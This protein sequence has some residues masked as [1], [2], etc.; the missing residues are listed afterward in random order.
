MSDR[1]KSRILV[2]DD[3]ITVC[4]SIKMA[5]QDD[6]YEID[7]A[8]SG[9][10]ALQK[11][12]ES[13]YDLVITDLMMPGISGLDLLKALQ[14]DHPDIL[15]IMITGYPTI[16]TAV[17]S[18]KFGAFDYIPKP[19]TPKDLRDIIARSLK[20]NRAAPEKKEKASPLIPPGYFYLTG[21]A[22]I[23][24]ENANK[25]LVGIMHEFITS[26]GGIKRVDIPPVNK[27]IYQGEVLT[28][29][30]DD[31]DRIHRVWSPASGRIIEVNSFLSENLYWLT[32]SP[33]D[34]GWLMRM[35][36]FR[37][38]EDLKELKKA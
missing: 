11:N 19:F 23:K 15:V 12:K 29:I 25:A 34:K 3:E 30:T 10:E 2:V 37:P 33:Y 16:R 38:E 9:E 6:Q 21:F 22:W 31:K 7:T 4:K 18:V 20:I 13:A 8:L 32:E 17:E 1:N 24:R 5:I 26:L 14:K 27:N 28:R 35:A 36:L